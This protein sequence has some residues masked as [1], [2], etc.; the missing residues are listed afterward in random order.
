MK[1]IKEW[2]SLSGPF[3]KTY[4]VFTEEQAT[5]SIVFSPHLK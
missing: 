3:G 2:M 4:N 5:P 1:I